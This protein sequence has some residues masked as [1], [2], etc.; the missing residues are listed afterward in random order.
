MQEKLPLK[1]QTLEDQ[2]TAI[3]LFLHSKVITKDIAIE[4]KEAL[5]PMHMS[6]AY[7]VLERVKQYIYNAPK[8]EIVPEELSD[9]VKLCSAIVLNHIAFFTRDQ[10]C[11]NVLPKVGYIA[12][13]Y[14]FDLLDKQSK[15]TYIKI[16]DQITDPS[17]DEFKT[18]FESRRYQN[19]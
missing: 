2:T 12:V 1:Y 7:L 10:V 17:Y 8:N 16:L 14:G 15:D 11:V 13:T 4:I 3:K 9:I 18:L 6:L 5:E 19:V